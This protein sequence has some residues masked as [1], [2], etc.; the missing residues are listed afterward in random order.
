MADRLAKSDWIAQG[1][2]TLARHGP[3]ALKIGALAAKLRV[4]RGSFYW[5]FRDH[6]DF[7]AQLLESWQESST[8]RIIRDLDAREAELD[9]LRDLMRR[10]FR[11]S[12]NLERAIRSWAAEDKDVA[13]VVASVDARRVAG[14]GKLLVEA[15]VKRDCALN[16]AAF[17][18]WAYLGQ[19]LVMHPRHAALSTSALNDI[20]RLFETTEG[21]SED[22]WRSRKSL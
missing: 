22:P 1:L 19:A 8:D 9:R 7:R 21:C 16:R 13:T 10:A 6:A 4:S 18:Y 12:R 2:E 5:H 14:L 20:A 15:G 11:G 3:N 17:L